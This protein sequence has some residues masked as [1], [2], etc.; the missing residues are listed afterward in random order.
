M[1]TI[2]QFR[3]DENN[4]VELFENSQT[5]FEINGILNGVPYA[6]VFN[7]LLMA[8]LFY[9]RQVMKLQMARVAA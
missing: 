6:V 5:E 7:N 8:N 4:W 9:Q 2:K 1:M 3:N